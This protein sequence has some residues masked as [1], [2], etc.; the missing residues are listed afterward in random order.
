[1][2][3]AILAAALFIFSPDAQTVGSNPRELPSQG[4]NLTTGET[5]IGLHAAP[6]ET[7]AACGWYQRDAGTP[8][9]CYSNEYAVV[10]GYVFSRQ[11]GTATAQYEKHWHKIQ[12]VKYS[13]MRI[14]AALQTLGYWAQVK[15]WIIDN[16]L[17]DLYL[18]AQD[19]A[20]DNE[21]FAIG[22]AILQAQLG[23]TDEQVETILK[24]A[25]L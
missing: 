10:S 9:I 2:T 13:K 11:S 17:Y 8:P 21:H 6:P 15:Q 24:E 20:S 12:P 18:A 22:L 25:E 19:F 1:M 7:R 14:V 3:S 5:V 4:R 23:L 16:D